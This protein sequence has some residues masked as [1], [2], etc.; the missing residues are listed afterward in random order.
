MVPIHDCI[1]NLVYCMRTENI[2]SVMCNGRW[3]MRDKK[4]LNVDEEEV[5]SLA[6]E[7][8]SKLLRRAG[9]KL[10]SR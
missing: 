7:A 2:V 5:I 8:S 1:S 4:I 9:I 3:I 6:K 10:P